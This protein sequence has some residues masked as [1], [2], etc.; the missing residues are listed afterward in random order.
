MDCII[1]TSPHMQPPGPSPRRWR[2]GGATGV[3]LAFLLCAACGSEVEDVAP[4]GRLSPPERAIRISVA[5]RG[6][7]PDLETTERVERDPE[8]LPD[9]VDAWLES[10]DFGR[11]MRDLHNDTLLVRADTDT[12]Y[13]QA[14]VLADYSTAQIHAATSEAPLRLIEDIIMS[15]QPYTR[16]VTADYA[17]F[18]EIGALVYGVPY[19]PDGPEWQASWWNDGRP[20]AGVLSSSEIYKRYVSNGENHNRR[21]AA[22]I[23]EALLCD[24]IPER[25]II[26][27]GSVFSF[28]GGTVTDR[29]QTDSMCLGCHTTLDPLAAFFWGFQEHFK[30]YRMYD[31]H[32][33]GIGCEE[34][35]ALTD[36]TSEHAFVTDL[37]Y[38]ITT[39]RPAN[40]DRW[41][42]LGLPA[43]ALYGRPGADLS[44]LGRLI[45][46]DPRFP[47]CTARNFLG[48][49][50]Q[51]RPS[52]VPSE[53]AE[54]LGR[55]FV[56]SGY[57]AKWLARTIVLGDRFGRVEPEREQGLV[58]L[59]TVTSQSYAQQVEHTTGFRWM[60]V[61]D[62][63]VCVEQLNCWGAVDLGRSNVFG[64]NGLMGGVDAMALMEPTHTP[65]PSK[66]LAMGRFASEAAGFVVDS[67]FSADP[68]ERRLL[69]HVEAD[70]RDE[71]EVRVQL[72]AL[73]GDILSQR[74]AVHGPEVDRLWDLFDGSV[75]RH[76]HPAEA[77]KLV[78]SALLQHP[79]LVL[80]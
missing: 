56:E 75:A 73:Y 29:V 49:F 25:D 34:A 74:V 67:D 2:A 31:L 79:Q 47:V 64:Y 66:V 42:E 63:G 41:S 68:S 36:E 15:D 38:P 54:S 11:V 62:P 53:V 39:Y 8:I 28:S 46:E 65:T 6:H 13:P 3:S 33:S 7:R 40:E 12:Q 72:T 45:A 76:D 70:T 23:A 17:M 26:A 58:G 51:V 30:V 44:D 52:E 16:V 14:G 10:P 43:P 32:A 24:S 1:G 55:G 5:L 19:D 9:L 20:R 59:L 37:C 18:H 80:Y 22:H 77:W 35:A 48:Y 27:V 78:I 50:H 21:R 57:S 71:L 4:D 60:A 69:T 61:G